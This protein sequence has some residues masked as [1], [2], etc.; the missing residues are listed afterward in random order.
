MSR[1]E[2]GYSGVSEAERSSMEREALRLKQGRRLVELG[3]HTQLGLSEEAY[4]QTL[5]KFEPQPEG[6]KGRFDLQVLVD[7]RLSS[8]VQHKTINAK[9]SIDSSII[10]DVTQAPS[11]PY[12]IWTHDASKYRQQSVA[13][14]AE[15]FG[16][17]EVGAT[18]K[19]VTALYLQHPEAFAGRAVYAAGSR[20]EGRHVPYLHRL[21]DERRPRLGRGGTNDR[22]HAFFGALSRGKKV[23]Q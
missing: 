12:V 8:K 7:P 4:L 14:A 6:Y 13:G 10:V 19:E 23:T 15:Q 2:S 21:N 3:F 20:S 18:Q 1:S 9:E 16:E 5:P 22:E 11:E 17:D